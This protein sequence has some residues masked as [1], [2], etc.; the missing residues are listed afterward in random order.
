MH[1]NVAPAIDSYG[2]ESS[3]G[4]LSNLRRGCTYLPHAG[5]GGHYELSRLIGVESVRMYARH[6]Y[7]RGRGAAP[8]KV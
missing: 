6:L 8:E 4:G 5:R 1:E 7:V 2:S 3:G